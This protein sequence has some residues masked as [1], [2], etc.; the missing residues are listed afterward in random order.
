ME[1]NRLESW[2]GLFWRKISPDRGDFKVQTKTKGK[3]IQCIEQP[4][5][6]VLRIDLMTTIKT[7]LDFPEVL[8]TEDI[9]TSYHNGLLQVTIPRILISHKYETTFWR[10][11]DRLLPLAS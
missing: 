1:S 4:E 3:K 10:P 7:I 6:Y 8:A 5:S 9:K 11:G 2:M